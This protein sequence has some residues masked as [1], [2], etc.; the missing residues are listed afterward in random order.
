MSLGRKA[1]N[2]PSRNFTKERFNREFGR[3]ASL[4]KIVTFIRLYYGL[5]S[6]GET[7]AVGLGSSYYR[8]AVYLETL[9][10]KFREDI[11][12]HDCLISPP[13]ISKYQYILST[14][15]RNRKPV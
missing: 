9:A 2:W 1:P 3:N 4:E 13:T 8:L 6:V 11:P 12:P 5:A 15:K 14:T 10:R 7:K